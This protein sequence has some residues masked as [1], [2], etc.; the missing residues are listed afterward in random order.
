MRL[1]GCDLHA[2]QQSIAI[3]DRDTGEMVEKTLTHEG[4]GVAGV[5]QHRVRP[6]VFEDLESR[7]A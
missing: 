5:V 3:L 6:R 4:V 7:R 2:S 1:V